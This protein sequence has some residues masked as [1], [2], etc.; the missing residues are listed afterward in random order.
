MT[1][2]PSTPDAASWK[3]WHTASKPA[4]RPT[5]TRASPH[6]NGC[7]PHNPQPAIRDVRPQVHHPMTSTGHGLIAI[8]AWYPSAEVREGSA[9]FVLAGHEALKETALLFASQQTLTD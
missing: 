5:S 9:R 7:S 2:S 6:W 3:T 1:A 8:G 4:R